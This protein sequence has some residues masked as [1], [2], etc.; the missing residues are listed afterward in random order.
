VVQ[1][2]VD[3]IDEIA[4]GMLITFGNTFIGHRRFGQLVC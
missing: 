4:P 3:A 1:H 2:V